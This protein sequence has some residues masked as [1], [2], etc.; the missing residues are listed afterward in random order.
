MMI[1]GG[2]SV[3]ALIHFNHTLK[4]Q[5]SSSPLQALIAEVMSE[6]ARKSVM[7]MV[8]ETVVVDV[9]AWCDM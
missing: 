2:F 5:P 9:A 4:T 6:A 8:V 3:G 7:A 1:P